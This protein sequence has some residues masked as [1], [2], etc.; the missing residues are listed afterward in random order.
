MISRSS[1]RWAWSSARPRAATNSTARCVSSSRAPRCLPSSPGIS[2]A[3]GTSVT[4]TYDADGNV[5][6]MTDAT[7]TTTYTYDALNRETGKTLPSGATFAYGYDGVGNMTSYADSGGTVSYTYSPVNTLST[8]TDPGTNE[9]TYAYN[10]EYQPTS[11]AYPNGATMTLTYTTAGQMASIVAKNSGGTELTGYTYS[12]VNPANGTATA[13]RYSMTDAS[14]ATTAYSYDVLNRLT[15]AKTT[16]GGTVT[17]DYQYAYDGNG[18][19]TSQDANGNS[20]AYTYNAANELTA[21]GATTY[22]YDANGNETG[23]SSGLS[24]TYNAANM[25]SSITPPNASAIAMTY[26]G[27]TQTQRVAAGSTGFQY[28]LV[29][30]ASQTGSG[31]TTYYTRTPSGQLVSERTP[32]GT[33]YYLFDGL[34]SVVG[35]TDSTGNLVNTYQYDP[36]GNVTSQTGTV[37]NPWLFASAYFDSATGLYKMGARYYDPTAGR[38]TQLDPKPGSGVSPNTLDGYA[39]VANDPIILVDLFGYSWSWYQFAK[40]TVS[41]GVGGAASGAVYGAL[42]GTVTL[43]VIGTVAGAGAGALVGL[44]AGSAWG[45]AGYIATFWW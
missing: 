39:Y 36:Y 16:S 10:A 23:N 45:A 30:L 7:G 11:I 19:R 9:T 20:T 13:L 12:Y 33:Y 5:T 14:G 43:P 3:D 18:N 1:Q 4:Y 8:L 42:G 31:A 38:W 29:G 41:N 6:A 32:G 21:A 22:S 37:A 40:S 27:A 25:T 2:Y 26:T 34:G 15:E 28:G 17:A 44:V 24:L 35:L